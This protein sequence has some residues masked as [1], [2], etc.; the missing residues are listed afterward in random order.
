MSSLV[1]C[2]LSVWVLFATTAALAEIVNSNGIPHICNTDQPRDGR[3]DVT[4]TELWRAGGEDEDTFFGLVPRVATDP[5]GNVYVLDS[6][7]CQVYVY[8]P[9]GEL[10]RTLFREG[11]GPGE[12]RRPRDM[13]LMGDGR[14]GLIQEFPG[15]ISYVHADGTPAGKIQLT[16]PE[17]GTVSLTACDASGDVLLF[18]GNHDR[19]GARPEIR[20]R[21]NV[22]ERYD[23][24]GHLQ[25]RYAETHAVYDF[26]DFRFVESEHLPV[27]WFTFAAAADGRV[28]LADAHDKYAVTVCAPDGTP[29]RIIERDYEPL[30]RT[31]GEHRRLELMILSA[32]AGAPFQPQIEINRRESALAYF[33]RAIQLHPD[34]D[35]WVLSGRGLRP[36]QAGVMAVFD[37][38]DEAGLFTE[39]VA[40]HADHDGRDVG[41]FLSGADRILVVMGYMDSL[42]AQFGNGTPMA[43]EGD[44]PQPPEVICYGMR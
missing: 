34:G 7:T 1:V 32:F 8:S 17:G 42:A 33:H 12:V 44:E 14:V 25:T 4:L 11:E 18:T 20:N 39:Q 38:F 28:Y 10:L 29:Q 21:V 9:D 41:I 23:P 6:Q 40:L 37:V 22:L 15:A 3:R 5:E 24:D 26:A 16:G 19:E 35:M 31:A 13:V 27:F 2:L 30:D 36:E 43:D